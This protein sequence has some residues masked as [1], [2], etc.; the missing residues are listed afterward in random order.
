[1]E[2]IY[3][4]FYQ[5]PRYR[6]SPIAQLRMEAGLLGRKSGRGFYDYRTGPTQ[7]EQKAPVPTDISQS[8]FW[9]AGSDQPEG[10]AIADLIRKSGARTESGGRPSDK[11]VCIVMPLGSDATTEAVR[12][13]LDPKR[14]IAIDTISPLDKHRTLMTTPATSA[15][16]IEQA[17]SLFAK[18]GASVAVIRDSAGFVA[19][20]VLAMIV[21]I[22]CDIAQQGIAE[23]TDIDLAVTLGL[24]YP[25][26]PLALG[27]SIG[28][29]KIL[30]VLE[31]LLSYYGDPRY[32]P[33]PWLKRRAALEMSL[34][35]Q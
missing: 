25:K 31:S 4:Q 13:D 1:M 28:A 20:R 11:A 18:D 14:T 29:R 2:S 8:V 16:T 21:N 27:D 30:T 10:R 7:T 17:R 33:S 32:R 26:G 24:G 23:P 12:L 22:G 9:I 34:L 35:T 6:P 19:Q 15:A 5:E 3:N